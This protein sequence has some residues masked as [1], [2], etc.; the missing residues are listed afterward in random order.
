MLAIEIKLKA[1]TER[2][3]NEGLCFN[4]KFYFNVSV[5]VCVRC[6]HCDGEN[7]LKDHRSAI[8][9]NFEYMFVE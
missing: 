4:W 7:D 5:C 9:Y 2:K 1:N 6:I 8:I 3:E